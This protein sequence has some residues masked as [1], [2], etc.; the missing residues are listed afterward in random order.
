M[1]AIRILLNIHAKNQKNRYFINN[2]VQ[3]FKL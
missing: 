2:Y 1:F 3:K